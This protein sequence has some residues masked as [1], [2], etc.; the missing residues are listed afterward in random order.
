MA[1][2][3]KQE[4]MIPEISVVIL[5]FQ[6]G[7]RLSAFV[8]RTIEILESLPVSWEIVLVANWNN[9]NDETPGEAKKI[10]AQQNH[11]KVVSE[12]KEGGMGWD[13][14]KGFEQASGRF[15]CL[16][17][18]DGQMPPESITDVYEKIKSE[19]LDFV[20]TYRTERGDS[21]L[22]KMNSY[23]YNLAFRLLF[24]SVRVRDANSKPKIFTREAYSRMS[25]KASDW[26]LDAEMLIQCARMKLRMAEV[27]VT[28][29]K[30]LNR[31]SFVKIDA[32]LEFIKNLLSAR[33]KE[34]FIRKD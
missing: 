27:P 19:K 21:W 29:D 32:I 16:I 18:G 26:F 12:F 17:D 23:T 28:F 5:C 9:E 20:M 1:D 24:P 10:A 11:I 6:E 4:K 30:C 2:K 15:I 31:K 3:N 25:P 7:R 8:N 22:R 13:A 14:R 33:I 34:F